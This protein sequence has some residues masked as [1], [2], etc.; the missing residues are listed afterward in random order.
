MGRQ[1]IWE[2]VIKIVVDLARQSEE[3]IKAM[4]ATLAYMNLPEVQL[5]E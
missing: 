1:Q 2:H 5:A 3:A 4:N